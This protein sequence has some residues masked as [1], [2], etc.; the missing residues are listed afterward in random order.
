VGDKGF[1]GAVRRR[2]PCAVR[3]SEGLE[4]AMIVDFVGAERSLSAL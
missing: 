4:S 3:P 1:I 2:N